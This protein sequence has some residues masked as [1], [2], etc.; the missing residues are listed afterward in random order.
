MYIMHK[1]LSSEQKITGMIR[2]LPVEIDHRIVRF[3]FWARARC[4]SS[5]SLRQTSLTTVILFRHASHTD[6]VIKSGAIDHAVSNLGKITLLFAF[7]YSV[8]L[9][10]NNIV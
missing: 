2:A 8:I 9:F 5:S 6:E 10:R 4:Y 3:S 1:S 7:S